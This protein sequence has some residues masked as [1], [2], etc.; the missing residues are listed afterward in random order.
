MVST[1]AKNAFFILVAQLSST[2]SRSFG[3]SA[4]K[5]SYII[6]RLLS[7]LFPVRTKE[8]GQETPWV[9]P[10]ALLRVQY[11][12]KI[13]EARWLNTWDRP[14]AYKQ[15]RLYVLLYNDNVY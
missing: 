10:C 7:T 6:E 8:C 12:V 11:P 5:K 1:Y 15:R 9:P 3:E 2:A 4:F 14:I 13:R